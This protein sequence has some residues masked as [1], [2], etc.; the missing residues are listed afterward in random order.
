MNNNFKNFANK[1]KNSKKALSPAI[2]IALLLAITISLVAAVGYS[3]TVVT[4]N[5]SNAPQA[6]FDVNI[7]K[8]SGVVI[9]QISG[10]SI[11]TSDLTLKFVYDNV[12]TIVKPTGNNT[13]FMNWVLFNVPG[14]STEPRFAG[15]AGVYGLQF[16]PPGRHELTQNYDIATGLYSQTVFAKVAN[17]PPPV[18]D[19]GAQPG[20]VANP[21][22]SPTPVATPG[23]SPAVV[24]DPGP[25]PPTA[26]DPGP[27][28]TPVASPGPS[29]APIANPG[30][31]PTPVAD[32]GLP[33]TAVADPGPEPPEATDPGPTPAEP[34]LIDYGT[35]EEFDAAHAQWLLDSAWQTDYDA[36]QTY[37]AWQSADSAY[38]TYLT[39]YA[40]WQSAYAN[41]Q[42]Y[43]TA[44]AT[45]QSAHTAYQAYQTALAAWQPLYDAYQ[46][47]LTASA[48]WQTANTAYQNYSTWSTRNAAYQAYLT[49]YASW[50]TANTAYQVYQTALASWQTA[51]TAYQNYTT[52]STRNAAYQAYL[53]TLA[54]WR[55]E[56]ET[57]TQ[58]LPV[59]G[60]G[61]QITNAQQ[62]NFPIPMRNWLEAGIKVDL[63]NDT[64]S[65]W[66]PAVNGGSYPAIAKYYDNWHGGDYNV[67]DGTGHYG[68]TYDTAATEFAMFYVANPN[69]N[70]FSSVR[71][72]SPSGLTL[73]YDANPQNDQ[74]KAWQDGYLVS[75]G[76][77][78]QGD[79]FYFR[80]SEFNS[81][82]YWQASSLPT[83][84]MKT[85]FGN[86]ILAPGSTLQSVAIGNGFGTDSN[87]AVISNWDKIASGDKVK[88]Y[89][90]YSPSSQVIWQGDV[91]V[92]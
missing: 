86:C 59:T 20:V 66:V 40:A 10:D 35:Q 24:A 69:N 14:T 84:D 89:I 49:A 32:P 51:N 2:A 17:P 79:A 31:S 91:V 88:V 15:G 36:Y 67:A 65:T 73:T 11:T 77:L 76:L 47:Y 57:M 43:L 87:H 18:T 62:P 34:V 82:F 50:Q 85:S 13:F 7:Y 68:N 74:N 38:Q 4:P 81:P 28:P 30:P 71:I 25:Q 33:P 42:A 19:P 72:T 46:A 16:N 9:K 6:T 80:L 45:W 70:T 3:A 63:F 5:I 52:W 58:P 56:L 54:G 64:A 44:S 1:F 37:A 39:E 55:T 60:I 92:Q 29:P 26:G 78:S 23:P 75:G 8:D 61:V 21:G 83:D 12:E 90:L 48:N 53:T 41:Y 27:S 22:P